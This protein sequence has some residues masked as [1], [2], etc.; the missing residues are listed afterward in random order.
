MTPSRPLRRPSWPWV[1]LG[2][3]IVTIV[4][5]VALFPAWTGGGVGGP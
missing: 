4:L 1:F 5:A 3:A 2:G